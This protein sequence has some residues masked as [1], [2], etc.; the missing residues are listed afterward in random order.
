MSVN[1]T[2][3]SESAFRAGDVLTCMSDGYPEPTLMWTDGSAASTTTVPKGWFNVTCAATGNFTTPCTAMDT[4]TGFGVG[5]YNNS[6]NN[7]KKKKKEEEYEEERICIA[8][9]GPK[10]QRRLMQHRRTK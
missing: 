2:P 10:I 5:K 6:N 1:V 7:K 4:I 8:P 9:L 3:P